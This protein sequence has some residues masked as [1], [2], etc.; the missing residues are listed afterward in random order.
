LYV[1]QSCNIH[2]HFH[3]S[4]VHICAQI[5]HHSLLP[6]PT[7]RRHAH[8]S[9]PSHYLCEAVCHAAALTA[10]LCAIP[11]L[12]QQYTPLIQAGQVKGGDA[13]M[14][15][16]HCSVYS[17]RMCVFVGIHM[18]GH[19]ERANLIAQHIHTFTHT[20]T[21]IHTHTYTQTHA[22]AHTCIHTHIHTHTCTRTH[23]LRHR[24]PTPDHHPTKPQ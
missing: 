21:H 18:S 6:T 8:A 24:L 7:A 5:T 19:A 15:S 12:R 11:W 10:L 23:R 2:Q 9:M 17:A 20:H 1:G 16:G 4:Q 22:R 14:L 13:E 3:Q